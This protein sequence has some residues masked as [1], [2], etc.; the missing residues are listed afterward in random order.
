VI[1]AHGLVAAIATV[2]PAAAS[3]HWVSTAT[4]ALAILALITFIGVYNRT[5]K[6]VNTALTAAALANRIRQLHD[7]IARRSGHLHD[8]RSDGRA[9]AWPGV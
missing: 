2:A 3:G 1:G 7:R 8:E 5:S 4:G 9:P 6:P